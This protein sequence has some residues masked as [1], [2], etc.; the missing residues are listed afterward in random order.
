MEELADYALRTAEK[1]MVEVY[2]AVDLSDSARKN[3]F[4]WRADGAISWVDEGD[5]GWS[6]P[7]PRTMDRA[8][9]RLK[10]WLGLYGER[11]K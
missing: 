9:A 4:F 10:V 7:S 6:V 5:E 2:G 1:G 11:S 3:E 8:L